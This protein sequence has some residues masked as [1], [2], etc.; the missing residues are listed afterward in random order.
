MK[1]Q[2]AGDNSQQYQI[3][4]LT[5]QQGIDEK[6]AREIYDEKYNIAKQDF[7]EEALRIANERVK[8]LEDRLIPKMEAVN[9]G[10]K[11]F[12]DPSFQLL[13]IDAQ[14]AAAAT[15]RSVDYDLLSE[16]LVHRIEKGN[17]RHTRT[18][19]HRA[20]EIVEDISDEALL[21]LT[22]VHS[23]NSFIPVSPECASAL[24]VLDEL[25]G[26]I[27]Y[28]KLPEGNEWIEDLDILDAIRVNHFGKFKSIKEYYA[29]TLNGIVTIGIKKGSDD[30]N[31]AIKILQDSGLMI[32]NL[33]I[34]NSLI[35]DYMRINVG[36]FEAIDSLMLV[37]VIGGV[38]MQVPL[39]EQQK[40][41]IKSIV[42][43]YIQDSK[44][45][46]SIEESFISEWDKR[47]NLVLLRRWLEKI[48]NSFSITSVGKVLAHANAQRCDSKLP[49]LNNG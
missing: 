10:L 30:H 33:F 15:E 47:S 35:Q 45:K 36:N 48:P 28:D 8:E 38:S 7:T 44:L 27:I 9:D 46:N 32:P 1:I 43:L 49:P 12:A 42:E 37:R 17:D 3:Q 19:I 23:L 25:Y 34:E 22:I 14:K 18:G 41:A 16:L 11:A 31:K 39:S 21:G 24:D 40:T 26:R 6:R 4:N 13:L 2:K 20:V 5:I 29:S